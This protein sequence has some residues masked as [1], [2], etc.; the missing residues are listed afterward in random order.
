MI[1]FLT[2]YS[3]EQNYH[4]RFSS[5][6]EKI[7]FIAVSDEQNIDRIIIHDHHITKIILN[8]YY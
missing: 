6:G 1:T 5:P 2:H 7:D 3:N 8:P 4:F